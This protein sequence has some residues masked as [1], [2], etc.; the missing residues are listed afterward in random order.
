M[1]Y[2]Y[3]NRLEFKCNCCELNHTNKYFI[4]KLDIARGIAGAKFKI[5]SGFRCLKHNLNVGGNPDS[6]HLK[7][8]AADI[9]IKSSSDRWKIVN[10]LIQ[11]GFSR[12]GIAET[13][14]HVDED[15][16]KAQN[17]IWYY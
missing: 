11:V 5:N 1:N 13:F 7:G 2:K 8:L 6:S 9:R 15:D 4:E 3:F 14:I 16:D 12:I 17:V 10:A